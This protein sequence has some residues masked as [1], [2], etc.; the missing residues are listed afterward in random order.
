M[1]LIKLATA[2]RALQMY[3]H[4]AHNL[5]KGESFFADHEYFADLYS[6]AEG[7]YDSLIERS[8]GKGKKPSLK[9]IVS[10]VSKIVS[11]L[12]EDKFFEHCLIL[13]NEIIK[14]CEEL[15]KKENLGTNNL[16]ADLADKL[17]VHVYKLKQ[18]VG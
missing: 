5:T 9:S 16:I 8:I 4:Q 17:E 7:S 10:D 15:A 1:D 2:F 12:P 11:A 14:E 3:S 13:V 18:R 6:F